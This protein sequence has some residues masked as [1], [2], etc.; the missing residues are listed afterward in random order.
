MISTWFVFKSHRG[1]VSC[2]QAELGQGAPGSGRQMGSLGAL[3]CG[4]CL[5]PHG[6]SVESWDQG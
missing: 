2:I 1:G 4:S 3:S 5:Q 6:L